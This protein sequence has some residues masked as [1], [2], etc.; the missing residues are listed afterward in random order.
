[1]S[2]TFFEITVL[3]EHWL[4][5][6]AETFAIVYKNANQLSMKVCDVILDIYPLNL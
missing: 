1:M 5:L 2:Q 3:S 6:L 4:L